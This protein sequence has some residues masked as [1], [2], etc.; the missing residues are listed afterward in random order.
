MGTCIQVSIIELTSLPCLFVICRKRPISAHLLPRMQSRETP[1]TA[2]ETE[3]QRKDPGYGAEQPVYLSIAPPIG[4]HTFTRQDT[5]VHK[6][7]SA[8]AQASTKWLGRAG[9]RTSVRMLRDMRLVSTKQ[10]YVEAEDEPE[11]Q[12]LHGK[13][14]AARVSM[15]DLS[16]QS[17]LLT[18]EEVW[19][20]AEL[21][22]SREALT[23]IRSDDDSE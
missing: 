7:A 11:I 6:L 12:I 1:R 4:S 13:P 2:T 3:V 15:A 16:R 20:Q 9:D 10:R 23:R 19:K 8:H 5:A 22:R 21:M 18:A 14:F 17:G